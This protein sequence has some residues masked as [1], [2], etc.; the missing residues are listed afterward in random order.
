MK[1]KT[2]NIKYNYIYVELEKKKENLSIKIILYKIN[3]ENA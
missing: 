3:R 2:E 1:I